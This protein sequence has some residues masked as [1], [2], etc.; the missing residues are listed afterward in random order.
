MAIVRKSS[1]VCVLTLVTVLYSM[2]LNAAPLLKPGQ[3]LVFL[4]D[5]ITQQRI[6]T[7]YVMNYFTLRYPGSRFSFRNVGIGGDQASWAVGRIDRDVLSLK[8]DVVTI[9]FGA[10]DVGYKPFT[11]EAFDDYINSLKTMIET[12]KKA[13]I[14]VVLLT[15]TVVDDVT[16]ASF[17]PFMNEA[18]SMFRDGAL[19]LA[20]E[21]K[22]P[23]YDLHALMMDVQTRA[24]VDDQW[25]TIFLDGVHPN[26]AGHSLV[27][28]AVLRALGAIEQPASLTVDAGSKQFQA[29]KCRL[30]NLRISERMLSFTRTDDA[31]PT[32]FD[33]NT[34]S[35]RKYIDISNELNR[36]MFMVS[37]LSKGSWKLTVQDTVIG[38]FTSEALATGVNLAVYDGPW[39]QMGRSVNAISKTQEDFYL[40]NWRIS[41]DQMPETVLTADQ[42]AAAKMQMDNITA[43]MENTRLDA[44]ANR[45]WNWKLEK[46]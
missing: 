19:A 23:A 39:M 28:L 3:R 11:Q 14:Q 9:C 24:K 8:P 6:Y 27:A 41:R 22:I 21:Q 30:T 1:F 4:G 25:F 20:R 32:W 5:S 13:H 35:I 17:K 10:N 40:S 36:Y 26:N 46:L 29:E 33:S 15:P 7:R 34:T 31:L 12:L 16:V 45:T 37:G 42:T 2:S 38:T 43:L 18:L 44:T